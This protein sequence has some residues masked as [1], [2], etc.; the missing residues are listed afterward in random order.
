M[1]M[2]ERDN[3]ESILC[4]NRLD[5]TLK[6]YGM[7][8]VSEREKVRKFCTPAYF[9]KDKALHRSGDIANSVFFIC[10]GLVRFYYISEE[11]KEY[12]KSF[13]H[14]NQFAGA[15][16]YAA[17]PEPCRFYIQALEPTHTLAISLEG[18][19]TLYQESLAWANLGRLHMESLAVRKTSREAGFLLDSAEQRY[20][21]FLAQEPG[22]VQRL[23][24]YQIASYLGITDV[25]LSRIR[26]RIK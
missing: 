20:K 4:F 18:L 6:K 19:N 21:T 17:Q 10:S 14:E 9:P 16:Q 2:D 13:S 23:P 12:N 24:L 11:G 3:E 8:D 1:K 22:L 25:A 15:V 5:E 26:K 7:F